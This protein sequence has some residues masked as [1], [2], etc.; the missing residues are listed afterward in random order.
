MSLT[1]TT[2]II[3]NPR[4]P[5][6]HRANW[7][8]LQAVNDGTDSELEALDDRIDV[9]EAAF[10]LQS[11]LFDSTT[12][13]GAPLYVSSSGH[14]ERA[15]A[16]ALATSDVVGLAYEA[17]TSGQTGQY[18]QNGF[19][20]LADWS[21][22]IGSANLTAGTRYFLDTTTGQLTATAPSTIGQVVVWVGTAVSTTR[23]NI[24][25]HQRV[26]L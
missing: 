9:L 4:T 2:V 16:G 13:A 8:R 18:L 10:G 20:T 6:Q 22:I 11:A 12:A 15:N 23:M 17:V 26:R 14:V 21:A 3:P 19:L 5:A 7:S 25:I 1:D 24:R